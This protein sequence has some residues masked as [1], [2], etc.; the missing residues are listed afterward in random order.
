MFYPH[1]P[2]QDAKSGVVT[3]DGENLI[4]QVDLGNGRTYTVVRDVNNFISQI[5]DGVRTWLFTRD[6]NN[7]IISWIVT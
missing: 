2:S 5:S 1:D 3:R 6:A 7:Y 4:S